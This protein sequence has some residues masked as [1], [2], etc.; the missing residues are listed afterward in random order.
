MK[1][2]LTAQPSFGL[3]RTRVRGKVRD[4]RSEDMISYNSSDHIIS[5]DEVVRTLGF[6]P[7]VSQSKFELL[8][9]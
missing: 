9:V 6:M 7:S 3:R 5:V 1:L 2:I 8:M 4:L